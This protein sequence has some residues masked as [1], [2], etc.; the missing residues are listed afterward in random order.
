VFGVA[1]G[2][3]WWIRAWRWI[4]CTGVHRIHHGTRIHHDLFPARRVTGTAAL[5]RAVQR[6]R[7]VTPR[8]YRW[9]EP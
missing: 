6:G 3:A 8:D 7:M 2:F 5:R 4:G 9:A 1:P